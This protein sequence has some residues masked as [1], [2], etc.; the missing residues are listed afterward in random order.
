MFLRLKHKNGVVLAGLLLFLGLTAFFTVDLFLSC[1][2]SVNQPKKY[3]QAME[4]G[5]DYLSNAEIREFLALYLWQSR[6][7]QGCYRLAV[8]N[9]S[10]AIAMR[11]DSVEAYSN[12]AAVYGALKQY[13]QAVTDYETVLT[14]NPQD[15][16]ALLGIAIA[17]EKNG[18]SELAM[19]TY[20]EAIA[21]MK[22]S[23]YWATLHPEAIAQY[24]K[25][26]KALQGQ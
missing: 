8:E 25:K 22:T 6:K 5:N 16:H 12:R 14:L 24:E 9:F 13:P 23:D 10:E 11:P 3:A 4:R 20:E 2:G 26:L 1:D 21:Q 7:A 15:Q 18:Q 19:E 17:Y